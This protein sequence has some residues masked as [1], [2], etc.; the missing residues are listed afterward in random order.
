MH[1][2]VLT[3]NLPIG[4][5][6]VGFADDVVLT[7]LDEMLKEVDILTTVAIDAIGN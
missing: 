2:S 3:L 1:N 5:E 6:F 4:D 7:V